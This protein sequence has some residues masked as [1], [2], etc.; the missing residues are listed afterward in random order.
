[1]ARRCECC[2]RCPVSVPSKGD[3]SND[4]MP[5]AD[6]LRELP[7][8]TLTDAAGVYDLEAEGSSSALEFVW[9][10]KV[11]AEHRS[12]VM[13]AGRIPSAADRRW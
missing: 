4:L 6:R 8:G 3:T 1:M 10:L 9:W 7:F 11:T 13:P 12:G 2:R 5:V